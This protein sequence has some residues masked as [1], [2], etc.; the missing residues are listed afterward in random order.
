M[1]VMLLRRLALACVTILGVV[2]LV[3]CLLHLV[4]GDPVDAM[5]GETASVADRAALRRSLGLDRPILHQ[6]AEYVAGLAQGNLGLSLIDGKPVWVAIATRFPATLELAGAALLVAI[7]I[8]LPF[9]VAGAAWPHRAFDR[10]AQGF[11]ILAVSTPSFWLGP[12]LILVFSIAL[13]WTPVSGRGGPSHVLLPALTLG[14]GMSALL[15]RMLRAA[16]L[17]RLNDAYIRSARAKGLSETVVFF[18]HALRNAVLP[19]VTVL[20]LQIGG[21]LGGAILTET[22]FA[23]P[24]VGRLL[25]QSIQARD[26]PV[27]QGCILV[28]ALSYVAVNLLTD[29]LQATLDPRMAHR[30]GS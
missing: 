23:W 4:P 9:G 8:A 16:L 25:L 2:T 7:A 18:K 10:V 14:L 24:G 15:S 30:A 21:L 28:I 13:E 29:V 11:A 1:A 20:G 27:V 26:Y 3:F 22:I 12:L 6:Y 19:V 17:D 5:L